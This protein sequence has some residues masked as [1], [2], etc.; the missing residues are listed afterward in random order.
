MVPYS[1]LWEIHT[2]IGDGEKIEKL[3]STQNRWAKHDDDDE[4]DRWIKSQLDVT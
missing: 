4:E 3:L 1:L 2:I